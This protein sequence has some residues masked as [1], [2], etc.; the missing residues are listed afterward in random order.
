MYC[1]CTLICTGHIGK[2]ISQIRCNPPWTSSFCRRIG[3]V[4]RYKFSNFREIKGLPCGAMRR[5]IDALLSSL[6][7]VQD[8]FDAGQIYVPSAATALLLR[9]CIPS[10]RKVRALRHKSP[11]PPFYKG[12]GLFAVR[13]TSEVLRHDSSRAIDLCCDCSPP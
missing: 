5:L 6:T 7:S 11:S 3:L 1:T 2:V 9:C 12:G 8:R 10:S 13:S 4:K